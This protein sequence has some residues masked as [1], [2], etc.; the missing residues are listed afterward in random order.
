MSESTAP[1]PEEKGTPAPEIAEP[2]AEVVKPDIEAQKTLA[3]LITVV[4]KPCLWM[5]C[6]HLTYAIQQGAFL[7]LPIE[8][9]SNIMQNLIRGQKTLGGWTPPESKKAEPEA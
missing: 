5:M 8:D 1:N 9:Q 4:S 3:A 6:N 2:S 7:K